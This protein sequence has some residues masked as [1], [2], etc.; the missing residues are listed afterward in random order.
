MGTRK[1]ETVSFHIVNNITNP[2]KKQHM[3]THDYSYK[4]AV[5]FISSTSVEEVNPF[6]Y[7][8]ALPPRMADLNLMG[9]GVRAVRLT[10][11]GIIIAFV[12]R[13]AFVDYMD[14]EIPVVRASQPLFVCMLCVGTAGMASSLITSSQQEPVQ[15][16]DIACMPS[17]W[18]LSIGFV[19]S[20][21]ALLSKT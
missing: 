2:P 14:R 11:A 13:M 15:N 9:S 16:L 4:A 19:T 20:F 12:C 1:V 18:L 17:L 5:V 21:S 6:I 3:I 10:L 8:D 7:W